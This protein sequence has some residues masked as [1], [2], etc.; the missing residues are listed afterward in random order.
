MTFWIWD[1]ETGDK[2]SGP[3]TYP[4]KN[5]LA[6]AMVFTPGYPQM[7]LSP[8]GKWMV[9][10]EKEDNGTFHVE[11]VK[12]DHELF[13]RVGSWD[14]MLNIAF[15]PDSQRVA[16][17]WTSK[18]IRVYSLDPSQAPSRILDL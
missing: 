1:A 10:H 15:S 6:L 11:L 18:N 12:R 7:A 2:I 9:K 3:W 13:T 8:D 17:C 4:P 16:S 14:F 5:T